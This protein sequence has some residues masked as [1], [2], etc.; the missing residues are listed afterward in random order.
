MATTAL[1]PLAWRAGDNVTINLVGSGGTTWAS[2]V[3]VF[4]IA[5]IAGAT[6]VSQT[7][8]STT[9][10]S[11][12]VA[13]PAN[14]AGTLTVSNNSDASTATQKVVAFQKMKDDSFQRAN[15]SVGAAGTQAGVGGNW[16][17][18]SVTPALGGN[19]WRINDNKLVGQGS[20]TAGSLLNRVTSENGVDQMVVVD[21]VMD[22]TNQTLGLNLRVQGDTARYYLLAG[23]PTFRFNRVTSA[24]AISSLLNNVL[25]DP[26]RG[27]GVY[28]AGDSVTIVFFVTDVGGS[29]V[30]CAS[31]TN[32]TTGY[33]VQT[34]FQD[35]NALKITAAGTSGIDSVSAS[36]LLTVAR[37]RTYYPGVAS[38][39]ATPAGALSGA[40]NVSVALV[41]TGTA[42]VPGSSPFTMSASGSNGASI[43]SQTVT[44]ATHA[45]VVIN[46]GSA[47]DSL[48]LKEA[49]SGTATSVAVVATTLAIA[50]GLVSASRA[51]IVLTVTG[52]NQT[53]LTSA[54]AFSVSGVAGVAITN[55]TVIS[56]TQAQVTLT[57]GATTGT[58]T[59]TDATFPSANT[60]QVIF[61]LALNDP[62]I[63]ASPYN[64]RMNGALWAES[65]YA[66]AYRRVP[67]ITGAGGPLKIIYDPSPNIFGGLSAA[68]YPV[69][70]WSING[71]PITRSQ[72]N[73]SSGGVLQLAASLAA[74]TH[75]L[76]IR[77]V[78]I[79][80][81][82]GAARWYGGSARKVRIL[83]IQTDPSAVTY[84]IASRP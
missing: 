22:T 13:L 23:S 14:V 17:D 40:T 30:L 72:L 67:F 42:W 6:I 37:V 19:V 10:A 53:W 49:A 41:G 9:S 12:V 1:T 55:T 77:V 81:G 31:W 79:R 68:D 50:P 61:L 70:A 21:K 34:S 20:G 27:G 25:S 44:D 36:P 78:A 5:G 2:G 3:T 56:D 47:N 69:L 43:V 46:T 59:L 66:G 75:T 32:N 8:N 26:S 45:T 11:L 28:V 51:G 58:A 24:N 73:S 7:V 62:N 33:V 83:G 60:F 39:I 29:P 63:V 82:A 15:T 74:G 80:G 84:P 18:G 48:V 71:G 35:T 76:D 16:V 4:S 38:A 65:N 54:P 57:T 64:W 52:N